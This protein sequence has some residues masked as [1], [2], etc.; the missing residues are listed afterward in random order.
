MNKRFAQYSTN[1]STPAIFIFQNR[2]TNNPESFI[3]NRI[4]R[5]G[6]IPLHIS[7]VG[8]GA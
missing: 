2:L 3:E 8:S 6:Q 4:Q 5:D 7:K 1:S